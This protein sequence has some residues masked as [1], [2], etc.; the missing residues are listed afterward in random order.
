MRARSSRRVDGICSNVGGVQTPSRS[1]CCTTVARKSPLHILMSSVSGSGYLQM[2]N[3]DTTKASRLRHS[4]SLSY[5][6]GHLTL[7]TGVDLE[8]PR[9]VC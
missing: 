7:L 4:W 5:F 3:H 9:C 1:V 8:S 2:I 6:C